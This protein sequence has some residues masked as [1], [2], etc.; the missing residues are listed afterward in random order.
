MGSILTILPD[1]V[2]FT[3]KGNKLVASFRQDL[4][5][6]DELAVIV[7]TDL[8]NDTFEVKYIW[9]RS[10]QHVGTPAEWATDYGVPFINKTIE[11][12]YGGFDIENPPV[13]D[14]WWTPYAKYFRDTYVFDSTNGFH[15]K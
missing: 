12:H 5:E 7:G 11:D 13:P 2:Q 3:H 6:A 4:Q 14:E 9:R 8:G 10:N 15:L 1:D